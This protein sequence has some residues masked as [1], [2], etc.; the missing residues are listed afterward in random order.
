MFLSQAHTAWLVQEVIMKIDLPLES[1]CD[2][3]R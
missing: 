3:D 1:L 2:L